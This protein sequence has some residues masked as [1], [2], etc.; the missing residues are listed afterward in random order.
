MKTFRFL[1]S[2]FCLG[3][4][5]GAALFCS[6][7]AA[8]PASTG[9]G[10][11]YPGRPVRIVVPQ[12]PGG[13]LD[14]STRAVALKLA[15]T[16]GQ[17]VI[18]D[19]RPGA[20]GIIGIEAVAKAKPDG[21]TLSAA[22][23]SVLTVNPHVYKSLPYDTFRDLVPITQTVTN[24]IVLAVNPTV[25]ARTVKELIALGK[26]RPGD[27]SYGSFGVGN[28]THLAGELLGLETG[29][30]ATHVPYKGETPAVV[31]L[32]AGQVAFGFATAPGVAAHLQNRRLRLLAT[33]GERRATA[34]PDAPTMIESGVPNLIVT[35]WGG[36]LAP[37]GTPSEIIQ[38]VSRDTAQHL[39]NPEL[40]DRLSAIGAEPAG[41]TPDQFAAFMRRETEKWLRVSK[42]AGIYKSQ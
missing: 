41:T 35:G 23:T 20:N 1:P 31:D 11:A 15:E 37:T 22:F 18:V 34:F 29:I 36:F 14:I 19:N 24:T 4:A 5:A 21:Y 32:V 33:C 10:Q 13:G 7:A 3:C 6:T 17:Q 16:W 30:K 39:K 12:A 2:V 38:K 28:L 40:R 27:L 25:P 8:Q 26:S 42:A 9:S